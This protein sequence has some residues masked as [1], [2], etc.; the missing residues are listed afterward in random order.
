MKMITAA[1]I[2]AGLAVG[3]A[4]LAAPAQA[5][6]Y[7]V[8]SVVFWTGPSCIPTRSPQYPDGRY[9]GVIMICGGYSDARYTAAS[10]EYVGADPMPN[11]TTVTLGCV[12]YVN[13]SLVYSDYAPSGDRHDVNCL[14]YLP[15]ITNAQQRDT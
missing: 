2:T 6:Y 9:L 4:V 5:D 7:N 8:E 12:V 13:G 15:A 11:D 1:A 10:G 3:G 14:R